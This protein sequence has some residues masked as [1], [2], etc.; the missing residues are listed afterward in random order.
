MNNKHIK[1][2]EV[3]LQKKILPSPEKLCSPTTI[4]ETHLKED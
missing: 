2:R 1:E 4:S 3:I